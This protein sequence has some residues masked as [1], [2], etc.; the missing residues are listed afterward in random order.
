MSTQLALNLRLRDGS[1]FENFE[2]GRN[3]E[4]VEQLTGLARRAPGFQGWYLWG[5]RGSGKTHLVEAACRV[6]QQ[7]GTEPVVLPLA[8]RGDL[9]PTLLHEL[10][11][12]ALVCVDDIHAI[13]GDYEWEAA[14]LGVYERQ[15]AHGGKLL[16][17][18]EDAPA[19]IGFKLP[20]LATRLAALLAYPVHTLNDAEKISVL[21]RR[22]AQRGLE[23][24]EEVARYLL[25]RTPRDMHSLF[26]WLDRL[27]AASL[28]AQRRLT[29]PFLRQLEVQMT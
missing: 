17:S 22:A 15:R 16:V 28:A 11:P 27:D 18:A 2:A 19:R 25:E 23:L 7:S 9:S 13:A 29:I 5:A 26:T 24:P 4:L 1:S 21:T 3:R 14:I 20:D 12:A 8:E 6:A 10:E